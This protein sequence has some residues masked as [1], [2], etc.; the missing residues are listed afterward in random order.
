M[1]QSTAEQSTTKVE[2]NKPQIEGVMNKSVKGVLKRIVAYQFKR[3]FES[4]PG[5][6]SDRTNATTTFI[7][8]VPTSGIVGGLE[9]EIE[10]NGYIGTELIGKRVSYEDWTIE[11][12]LFDPTGRESDPTFRKGRR[13][14]E[15]TQR[16]ISIDGTLPSYESTAT[17]TYSI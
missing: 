3:H 15:R 17:G 16:L 7:I 4:V 11:T 9:H 5:C 13:D 6:N 2:Y 1:T 14:T 12:T 8:G 10:F